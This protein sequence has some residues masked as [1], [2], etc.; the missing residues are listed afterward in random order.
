MEKEKKKNQKIEHQKCKIL[1]I[2][3]KCRKVVSEREK[4]SGKKYGTRDKL[5][6]DTK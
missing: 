2:Q 3:R 5:G 4:R 6:N 1:G